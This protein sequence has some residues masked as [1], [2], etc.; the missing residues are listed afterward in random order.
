MPGQGHA[1]AQAAAALIV[2]YGG[3]VRIEQL[4]PVFGMG[5]MTLGW[6]SVPFTV[7]ATVGLIN[8]TNMIDGADGIAGALIAAALLML[9]AAAWYAGNLGLALVTLVIMAAT[10]GFLAHNFPLPWRRRARVFL[11]NGGSAFL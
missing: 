1:L 9:A 7:F 8:A 4:G 11:G 5:E 3:G 6:L 2:I 10:L